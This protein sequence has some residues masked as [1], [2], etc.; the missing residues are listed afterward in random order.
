VAYFFGTFAILI[1]WPRYV[2]GVSGRAADARHGAR[3][4][5]RV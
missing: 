3:R 5:R 2:R 1:E 4:R